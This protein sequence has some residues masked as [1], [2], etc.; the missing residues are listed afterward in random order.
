MKISFLAGTSPIVQSTE[1]SVGFYHRALGVP[2]DDPE[3][4]YPATSS[5]DGAKHFGLWNLRDVA[6]ACFGTDEWPS[7]RIA[8]Q[9]C[10]EFDVDSADGV[11]AAAAELEQGGYEILVAPK[12]EPWGQVVCRLQTPEGLM[13]CVTYTP[14]M[15]EKA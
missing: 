15:H 7:D 5:L 6:Q 3:G 11:A 2:I 9:A 14:W 4:D 10:F 12:T 8:P 13:V 1:A